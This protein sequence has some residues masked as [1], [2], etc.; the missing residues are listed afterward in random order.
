MSGYADRL[1]AMDDQYESA[2][3][4]TGGALVPDGEYEAVLERFDF[5]DPSAKGKEGGLKLV[6]ELSVTDGEYAGVAAPSVWHELEDPDRIG[7]TK[8]YLQMLGLEGIRL[9]QLESAL[10]PLAGATKVA[11]R[12]V[13]KGQY[14]NTYINE[15]IGKPGEADLTGA[16]TAPAAEEED[17]PF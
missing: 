11:I 14:R 5:W 6:T 3:A 10:E 16:P 1:A 15:V 8:G 2:E 13:T 4:R 7:W 17:L 12:V 9:S